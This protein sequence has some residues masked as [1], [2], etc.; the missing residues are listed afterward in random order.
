MR[1]VRFGGREGG[2]IDLN[3]IALAQLRIKTLAGSLQALILEIRQHLVAHFRQ[4]RN[5]RRELL[6][7][8]HE[9][10]PVAGPNGPAQAPGSA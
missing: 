5:S 1:R 7:N 4:V 8:P 9:M 10:K 2:L 3:A 6:R